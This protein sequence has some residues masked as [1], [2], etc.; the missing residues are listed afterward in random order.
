MNTHF[1]L[2][3]CVFLA[4]ITCKC[5]RRVNASISFQRAFA[6]SQPVLT[7]KP[8]VSIELTVLTRTD[9]SIKTSWTLPSNASESGDYIYTVCAMPTDSLVGVKVCCYT[10]ESNSCTV[11]YLDPSTGYSLTIEACRIGD[12]NT[13]SQKSPPLQTYTLPGVPQ[14]LRVKNKSAEGLMLTWSE[15]IPNTTN[16]SRYHVVVA[17]GEAVFLTKS[18]NTSEFNLSYSEL[19]ACRTVNFSVRICTREDDCG[20]FAVSQVITPP[21]F[22]DTRLLKIML[23]IFI[24][25]ILIVVLLILLFV[26]RK[27]IPFLRGLFAKKSHSSDVNLSSFSIKYYD[28]P[29]AQSPSGIP[30]PIPI[31]NFAANLQDLSSKNGIQALFKNMEALSRSEIEDKY[32][33]T[34]QVANQNSIRNRYKNMMPYD[35]SLVLI[36]RPWSS[37]S[38]DPQPE[39]TVDEAGK[40]YINASY[41]R[42]PEYGS[43]GEA[44][45]A[46]VASLPEYIATQGPLESTAADF[47]TMVC[48]QRC[49]LII[50]LC[51]CKEGGK[52]KCAQ[53]WPDGVVQTFD[54]K[55]CSVEVR[56]ESEESIGS[57]VRRQLRIHPSSEALPW[58]VTQLQFTGWPDYGVP[59]MESFYSLIAMQNSLL[60]MR[61]AGTECGPTVVHCSAGMGRTGTFMIGFFLLDRLRMN[62]LNVD[63]IG[64]ILATRKWRSNLVLTWTQLQ[65][66][67][68]FIDFCIV[69]EKSSAKQPAPVAIPLSSIEYENTADDPY[70]TTAQRD[71]Y[72]NHPWCDVPTA[73]KATSPLPLQQTKL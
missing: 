36:G 56:K 55:K 1:W 30:P 41:V 60:G 66:L 19:P 39:I 64:T 53:Y 43:G 73:G 10:S 37:A 15:P 16:F 71:D 68:N 12:F 17:D 65:F 11:P 35:Q 26:F 50:M 9:K 23:G 38:K 2:I 67:Y 6:G 22:E 8:A 14:N 5:S 20:A 13:C 7:A 59:S 51:Q 58:S 21:S 31:E 62:P 48:E 44:L 40:G 70:S 69:E 3:I 57:V 49:P 27:R 54:S 42:R 52:A 25:L 4:S 47:L 29:G 72:E 33:L 24:P 28:P 32:R 18:I 34:N 61:R 63:V 45:V 46:S